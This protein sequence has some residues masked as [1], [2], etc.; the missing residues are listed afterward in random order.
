M[1]L[2][3]LVEDKE[4]RISEQKVMISDLTR[5]KTSYDDSSFY[6]RQIEVLK[7]DHS[8]VLL[9]MT[10]ECS[11]YRKQLD[12]LREEHSKIK[13]TQINDQSHHKRILEL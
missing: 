2:E 8:K 1:E 13:F 4:K 12:Q 9:Q 11:N 10:E 7:E 6:K 3:K 5:S